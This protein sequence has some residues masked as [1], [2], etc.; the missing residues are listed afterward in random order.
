M[1]NNPWA[2][3][4]KE[5]KEAGQRLVQSLDTCLTNRVAAL[6]CL[7]AFD[8]ALEVVVKCLERIPKVE[9]V[10]KPGLTLK[11]SLREKEE[12]IREKER[13]IRRLREELEKLAGLERELEQRERERKELQKRLGRL[14][15]LQ[16]LVEKG[17]LEALRQQ[18]KE[19]ET[20]QELLEARNLEQAI[21]RAAQGLIRLT[22]EQFQ[23]LKKETQTLLIRVKGQEESLKRAKEDLDQIRERYRL[24]QEKWQR[25]QDELR[26]YEEA[27]RRVATALPESSH[28]RDALAAI[29]KVRELIR[30]V[31]EALRIAIEENEREQQ[32]KPLFLGG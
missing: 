20:L 29:E 13:E 21:T 30:A 4:L 6:K 28:Q 1:E 3:A 26:H 25:C 22:E 11:D 5:I 19:L 31:E 18:V 23:S 16:A 15:R 8:D 10:A 32:R 7:L 12:A 9:E 17:G 27:Y 14:Q 24:A 2:E